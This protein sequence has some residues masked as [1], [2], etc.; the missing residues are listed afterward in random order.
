MT[1][2]ALA[3]A[4]VWPECETAPGDHRIVGKSPEGSRQP[5]GETRTLARRL[6]WWLVAASLAM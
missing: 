6:K 2:P 3:A 1:M 4:P 5:G